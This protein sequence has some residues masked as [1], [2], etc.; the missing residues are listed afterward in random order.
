M[1]LKAALEIPLGQKAEDKRLLMFQEWAA[2]WIGEALDRPDFEA[3]E[4]TEYYD[5]TGTQF[6]PLRFRPVYASPTIAVRV[7]NSGHWGSTSGS[8][9]TET[10][11]TYGDDFAL[12]LD[13]GDG[14]TSRS[15]L[16]VRINDSWE[17][18][19]YRRRGLLSSFLG[20]GN[21]NV[22]VVYTGGYTADNLPASLRMATV[23][24]IAKLRHLYPLGQELTSE[25]YEERSISISPN[26]KYY[27]LGLV[28]GMIE[29]FRN[30]RW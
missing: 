30:R 23:T 6:I 7:D 26:S 9:G 14:L 21:G 5:G 1:E 16:L 24:L 8:F 27:L 19:F 13:Q 18:P 3:K 28:R 22:R 29:P 17:K 4:R 12:K 20:P 11:L 25:S 10:A 2:G 15:G